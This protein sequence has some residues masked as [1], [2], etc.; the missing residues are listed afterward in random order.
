M[1]KYTK[2]APKPRTTRTE[3]APPPQPTWPSYTV[4]A[5]LV[6][7]D[8]PRA[9]VSYN[10]NSIGVREGDEIDGGCVVL[11]IEA[12]GVTFQGEPGTKKYPYPS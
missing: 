7:D 4:T 10:G 9:W 11:R 3:P 1:E 2:P 6:G 8:D 12:D 5:V